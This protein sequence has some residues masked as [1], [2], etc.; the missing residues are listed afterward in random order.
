MAQKKKGKSRRRQKIPILATAGMIIGMK[1]LWDAYKEGG[2]GR[3]MISLTG[4]DPNYGFNWRWATSSIP[5][6]LGAGGSMVAAKSGVNRYI[7]VPVFK[8]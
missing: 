7:K 8:L 3:A 5:M 1:N 4:Y 6:F 2:T